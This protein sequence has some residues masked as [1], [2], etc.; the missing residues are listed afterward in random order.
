MCGGMNK[1]LKIMCV[2]RP[3][4]GAVIVILMVCALFMA[5]AL[6]F[7][8][9]MQDTRADTATY[10]QTG[11]ADVA[12][13]SAV[14][15]AA[16]LLTADMQEGQADTLAESWV[17]VPHGRPVR[18]WR[19]RR[20]YAAALTNLNGQHWF[21]LPGPTT[22]TVVRYRFKLLDRVEPDAE[23]RTVGAAALY[24]GR[25][26]PTDDLN[27]ADAT[28][29]AALFERFDM[30][31]TDAV[32]RVQAVA[33]LL[34]DRDANHALVSPAAPDTEAVRFE[35]LV[36]QA[37]LRWQHFDDTL[38]LGRYYE[39]R[40]AH[41]FFLVQQARAV[42]NAALQRSNILVTLDDQP[43]ADLPGWQTYRAL[44]ER[45]KLPRWYG[46]MWQGITAATG[47]GLPEAQGGLFKYQP[48]V[49]N[50]EDTLQFDDGVVAR[51][52]GANG[53]RQ[54]VT[55][56]GW[57]SSLND[58]QRVR[59]PAVRARGAFFTTAPGAPDCFML[60]NLA[61]DA[62]YEMLLCSGT[63]YPQPLDAAVSL[64]GIDQL[65]ATRVDEQ[66]WATVLAGQPIAAR[67][68]WRGDFIEVIVRAPQTGVSAARPFY[69][70]GALLRQPP[71]IVL[72]NTA[73]TPIGVRDW[74][75][76]YRLGTRLFWTPPFTSAQAYS[77]A[78]R[79]AVQSHSPCMPAGGALIVTPSAALLDWFIGAVPDG[80]WGG[81]AGEETPVVETS[82]AAWGPRL[83][84][85]R[86]RARREL[87]ATST[88]DRNLAWETDWVL[89]TPEIDW[90]R[91][92]AES[93]AGEIV[94]VDLDGPAG[95][96]PA[97][98]GVIVAQHG[99]EV[100]VRLAGARTRFAHPR[101][102]TLQ[103]CALPRA[104]RECWLVMP[105]GRV[106]SR[107]QTPNASARA[108]DGCLQYLRDADGTLRAQ[109]L[110]WERLRAAVLHA[111]R[112]RDTTSAQH[113]APYSGAYEKL[114]A[115]ERAGLD[116]TSD[117]Y[118]HAAEFRGCGD[119][120]RTSCTGL[121]LVADRARVQRVREGWWH[122]AAPAPA[123]PPGAPGLLYNQAQLADGASVAVR[124]CTRAGF[125]LHPAPELL[126]TQVLGQTVVLG[127]SRT[128]PGVHVFGMPGTC[129]FVWTNMPRIEQPLTITLAGISA[130]AW[131]PPAHRAQWLADTN[132]PV[133]LTVAAWNHH[134]K[135]FDELCAHATFDEAERLQAGALTPAHLANGELRLRV[136]TEQVLQPGTCELW[137][138][139]VYLHPF[140]RTPALNLNTATPAA[141][142]DLC[143]A[144]V[145][146]VV[147]QLQASGACASFS[148][149]VQQLGTNA[150]LE[151]CGVQSTT[152][153]MCVEGALVRRTATGDTL[154]ARRTQCLRFTR[155]PARLLGGPVLRRT[156][157]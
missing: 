119:A 130:R 33:R 109:Q 69:L 87:T 151:A 156:P 22:T 24:R 141:L 153:D 11:W 38:R 66:G 94:L 83:A 97:I 61:R 78:A 39:E 57:F 142:R 60:T 138:E 140:A 23:V 52:A 77:G 63:G 41:N 101:G 104:V 35:R 122:W 9:L 73:A 10:I 108:T 26:Q 76:G 127:P 1:L 43:T 120:D 54:T 65:Q 21:E 103:F 18:G 123:F 121:T 135:R 7:V 6:L 62:R 30:R 98:P 93:V 44:R 68:L 42:Y 5:C 115:V 85:A 114:R 58:Q 110:P 145:L 79:R 67:Q 32:W 70:E 147:T 45:S 25:W 50:S 106:A 150:L 137:L 46:G 4:G 51:F 128:R 2:R 143:G 107:V 111:G 47:S 82:W 91:D 133:T 12:L 102:A 89:Q 48:V 15:H 131:R 20:N 14:Q 71:F 136:T 146:P 40:A 126:T 117:W 17:T 27:A 92:V 105:D 19:A 80:Q 124:A 112:Q 28:Q 16:A 34:D 75:L 148:E 53:I 90:T 118:L 86:L 36:L 134:T 95:T 29:M 125:A 64:F 100:T 113:N 55:F 157:R 116:T 152:F 99:R 139:G 8:E 13:E 96:Q 49:S 37:D 31:A 3:R 88:A 149:L 56:D 129:T 144:Q 84:V 155:E 72:R 59:M 81:S 74:R 154:L 132:A